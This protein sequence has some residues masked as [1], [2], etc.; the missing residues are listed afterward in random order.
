MPAPEAK[1]QM[2]KF[3]TAALLTLA[4]F[5]PALAQEQRYCNNR[6]VGGNFSKQLR[7]QLDGR[8]EMQYFMTLTNTTNRFIHFRLSFN[9]PDVQD[10]QHPARS[11]PAGMS[12]HFRIGTSF[13]AGR[14]SVSIWQPDT[15]GTDIPLADIAR[16][17]TI[18]CGN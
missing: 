11:M 1:T 16:Y 13:M 9:G 5:S 6:L 10:G 4:W 8:Q 7:T 14:N 18:T 12:Q 17:I 15:P 2:M 3:L